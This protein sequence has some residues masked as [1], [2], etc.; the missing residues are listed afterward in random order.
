M[1]LGTKDYSFSIIFKEAI[2][3]PFYWAFHIYTFVVNHF[4][5]ILLFYFD[6]TPH[7][8]FYLQLWCKLFWSSSPLGMVIFLPLVHLLPHLLDCGS[9]VIILLYW[10]LWL[11]LCI[12]RYLLLLLCVRCLCL[13][14]PFLFLLLVSIILY[15]IAVYRTLYHWLAVF[16]IL[17]VIC[18]LS[19]GASLLPRMS[20]ALLELPIGL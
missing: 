6:S 1:I 10:Y 19:F 16:L 4:L 17:Y 18:L 3:E 7:V 9:F 11:M 15:D 14:A 13:L 20:I 12:Y 8:P 5:L 2:P